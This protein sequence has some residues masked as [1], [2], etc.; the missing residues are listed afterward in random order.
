MKE[1]P[2][3]QY[4]VSLIIETHAG[5]PEGWDWNEMIVTEAVEHVSHVMA[6]TIYP[7]HISAPNVVEVS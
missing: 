4:M 5:H 7:E 2:L 1:K 6:H 3:K